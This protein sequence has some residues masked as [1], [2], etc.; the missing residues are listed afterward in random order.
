MGWQDVRLV[1][2]SKDLRGKLPSLSSP[3]LVSVGQTEMVRFNCGGNQIDSVLNGN[4]LRRCRS[5]LDCTIFLSPQCV[6]ESSQSWRKARNRCSGNEFAVHTKAASFCHKVSSQPHIQTWLDQI[7]GCLKIQSLISWPLG[8]GRPWLS[9]PALGRKRCFQH[10][11]HGYRRCFWCFLLMLPEVAFD[12]VNMQSSHTI[13]LPTALWLAQ[14]DCIYK[15]AMF[16]H[17]IACQ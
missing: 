8:A 7:L 2:L 12:A 16:H 3:M 15:I 1:N 5:A 11:V 10:F 13:F 6:N 17:E 4:E 14:T 9:R